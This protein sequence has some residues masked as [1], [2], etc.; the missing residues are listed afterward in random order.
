[1]SQFQVTIDKYGMLWVTAGRVIDLS[2]ATSTYYSLGAASFDPQNGISPVRF[3]STKAQLPVGGSGTA[4]TIS[5]T[6]SET[7]APIGVFWRS[8]PD[9]WRDQY[10]NTIE[11]DPG[12]GDTSIFAP[13]GTTEI[14]NATGLS[15]APVGTFSSTTDGED[16]YNGGTP[17][18]LT[19]TAESGAP[20]TYLT[21]T[22]DDN[23]VQGGRY[24]ASGGIYESDD[25][26]TWTVTMSSGTVTLDDG[27]DPV[28][29]GTITDLLDWTSD[30]A[31]T[32]YG[33]DTYNNGIPFGV[34]VTQAP[35][36]PIEG[37]VW[38]ELELSSGALVGATGPFF[39]ASLP[40]N[41]STR[42]VVPLAYSDGFGV[43]EQI[44]EGSIFWR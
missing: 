31:S 10:G 8:A 27:T 21:V 6:L 17:F 33:Q 39:G 44:H 23:I 25:D 5:G 35:I 19:A 36:D 41:S 28:A 14:A 7:N 38:I 29:T 42:E 9:T 30:L 40:A 24:S 3:A 4:A 18:S 22:N 37:W 34:A 43:V 16:I 12:T 11:A 26:P 15:P 20:A 32:T 1:M 13:D 2:A